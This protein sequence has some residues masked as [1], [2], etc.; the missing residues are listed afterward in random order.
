MLLKLCEIDF[1]PRV[2][3]IV[4]LPRFWKR[5]WN[6]TRNAPGWF[7]GGQAPVIDRL[8]MLHP[9]VVPEKPKVFSAPANPLWLFAPNGRSKLNTFTFW[10]KTGFSHGV[11]GENGPGCPVETN[12]LIL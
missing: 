4:T 6:E 2:T 5:T 8:P 12:Q 10:P 9:S 1:P 7:C 11:P 3:V